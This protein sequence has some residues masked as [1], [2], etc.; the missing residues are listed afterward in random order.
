ML[1]ELRAIPRHYLLIDCAYDHCVEDADA[2][3]DRVDNVHIETRHYGKHVMSL[4]L[5]RCV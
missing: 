4:S 1:L 5:I 2:A 3:D